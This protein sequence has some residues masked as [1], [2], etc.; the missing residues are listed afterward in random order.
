[1]K[2]VLLTSLLMAMTSITACELID[3]TQTTSQPTQTFAQSRLRIMTYNVK[4]KGAPSDS[5]GEFQD[6]TGQQISH[7]DRAHLIATDILQMGDIDVVAF[8]EVFVESAQ[9]QFVNDLHVMYPYYVEYLDDSANLYSDSGL[10]LFSKH[11]FIKPDSDKWYA[12]NVIANNGSGID[13]NSD[14]ITQWGAVGFSN[15]GGD[16]ASYDCLANKGAGFVRIQHSSTGEVFNVA[17]SHTQS[18]YSD[19]NEDKAREIRH[20]QL[21]MVETMIRDSLSKENFEGQRLFFIGDLNIDGNPFGDT[22]EYI[23]TFRGETPFYSCMTDPICPD[24]G[25][26]D[27]RVFYDMWREDTVPTDIGRTNG[28][29]LIFEHEPAVKLTHGSRFDYILH[30]RPKAEVERSP[31][32]T[33]HMMIP[34]KIAGNHGERSDHLPILAD[35][36]FDAPF[37]NPR[38]PEDIVFGPNFTGPSTVV[39]NSPNHQITYPGSMQWYRINQRGAYSMRITGAA[40][41]DFKVYHNTDLSRPIDDYYGIETRFGLKFDLPNPPYYIQV[42]SNDPSFTGNYSLHVHQHRCTSVYDSCPLRPAVAKRYPW[43]SSPTNPTNTI[44]YDVVTEL[45]DSGAFP[46]LNFRFLKNV[47]NDYELDILDG[48]SLVPISQIPADSWDVYESSPVGIFASPVPLNA[49]PNGPKRYLLE[50]ART[51]LVAEKTRLTYTTNLTFIEPRTL[52]CIV[53]NDN[54]PDQTDEIFAFFDVDSLHG[55]KTLMPESPPYSPYIK[56]GNFDEETVSSTSF[57]N[58]LGIIRYINQVVANLTDEDAGTN[59]NNDYLDTRDESLVSNGA[60]KP[61]GRDTAPNSNAVVTWEDTAG[62]SPDYRY[63]MHFGVRHERHTS[64]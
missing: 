55:H 57:Q 6:Q 30:N 39:F 47:G 5:S 41:V 51:G 43:P 20:S 29:D 56:I 62:D 23:S 33:Q 44:Y 59:G 16:C 2:H 15:Y 50:V 40:S 11:P 27:K 60:I 45:A 8:N 58:K 48:D 54:W 34:W 17:F 19:I 52:R 42:K 32:C 22:T 36:N 63:H 61:L 35:I 13:G 37:C 10:M 28:A 4:M 64:P 24:P 26:D 49:P 38:S 1:M 21:E 18:S 14:P 12:D 7:Q 53:R 9:K 31:M 25:S 46:T 3:P